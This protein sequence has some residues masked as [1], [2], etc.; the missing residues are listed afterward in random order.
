MRFINR[1]TET[2]DASM[3][4]SSVHACVCVCVCERERER[5]R[6]GKY[7]MVRSDQMVGLKV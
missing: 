6:D 5:E 7:K 1:W 4:I 2:F 3:Y